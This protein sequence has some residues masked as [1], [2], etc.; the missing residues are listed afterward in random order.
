MSVILYIIKYAIVSL[1]FLQSYQPFKNHSYC[2]EFKKL[3]SSCFCLEQFLA[4]G[5]LKMHR[6]KIA[7][8]MSFWQN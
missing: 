7:H 8:M 6:D 1:G 5:V 4:S 2:P 3:Q